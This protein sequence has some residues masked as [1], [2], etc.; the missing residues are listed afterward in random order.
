MGKLTTLFVAYRTAE[1]N[2]KAERNCTGEVVVM[3]V[4]IRQESKS[5]ELGK[6]VRVNIVLCMSQCDT[7]VHKLKLLI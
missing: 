2:I 6:G 3:V 4:V 7:L 5:M 1:L